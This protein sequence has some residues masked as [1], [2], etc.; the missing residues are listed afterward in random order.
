VEDTN[1][2]DGNALADKMEINLNMLGVLVLN[3]V[4]GE[5]D[6]A[7]VVAVDQ[8]GLWQE[9][10]QLYKQL[11][12]PAFWVGDD[13]LTL[14]GPG[15]TVVAQEH[16]VVQSGPPSIGTTGPVSISVDDK[17]WHRGTTKKQAVVKGALEVPMDALC[18]CEMGFTRVIHVEAHLLD[19]IGNVGSGED[20]VLESPSQATVGSRVTDRGPMSEETL[21]WV[22]TD[23]E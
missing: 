12:K 16:C 21:A 5:V 4:G 10:V 8:S 19:R 15:D 20:E 3:G 18:G 14:R 11:M 22:S 2:P 7:D 6:V 1:V 13:I 9:A 23:M 17:V